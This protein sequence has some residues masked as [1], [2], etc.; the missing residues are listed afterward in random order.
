MSLT[1]EKLKSRK[2]RRGTFVASIAVLPGPERSIEVLVQ[3]GVNAG[4]AVKVLTA[5]PLTLGAE[6]A[7]FQREKDGQFKNYVVSSA[8]SDRRS[9]DRLF[10]YSLDSSDRAGASFHDQRF[11]RSN[12]VTSVTLRPEEA[13]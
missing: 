1:G 5:I 11:E 2:N 9:K 6:I 12:P 4:D 3:N 7:L 8:I 10:I 13:V